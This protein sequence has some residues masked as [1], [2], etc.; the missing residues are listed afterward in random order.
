MFNC[1]TLQDS[2]HSGTVL[3][4]P[5]IKCFFFFFCMGVMSH[6]KFVE[7][8]LESYD[9]IMTSGGHNSDIKKIYLKNV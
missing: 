7:D 5:D 2:G 9:D 3:D 1:K 4:T 6:V 8:R